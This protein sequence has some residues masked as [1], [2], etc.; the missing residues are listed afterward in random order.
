MTRIEFLNE[1]IIEA[2]NFVNRLISELPEDLWYMIP[3][4][5]DSNLAW[6]IGHLLVSQNFHAITTITGVNEEVKRLMP[7]ARYNKIFNGMGT[8]HRSVEKNFLPASELKE[9]LD[10][11]H[12]ICLTN[13]SALDDKILNDPLEPIPFKHPVAN[14]KYEA[15]SWCFKHEMWHSA[16]MEAI[17]RALGFPIIWMK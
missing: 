12:T 15:L 2:R 3:E 11:V 14:T 5:T 8:L 9:Q 1:Q 4:G 6:Q 7:I 13:L 16:E 17:K 10:K